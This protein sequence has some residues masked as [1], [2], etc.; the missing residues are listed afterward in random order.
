MMRVLI[1]GSSRGI[2]RET[3]LMFLHKGYEVIGIDRDNATIDHEY[4]THYIADISSVDT[5]PEIN[6]INYLINNAGTQGEDDIANNLIGTINVTEK[7]AFQPCIKSV[8]NV[9]SA[10]ALTGAEF[11]HYAASKGGVNS[12]G[13][14]VALKL[15]EYKATCNNLCPGGV[16]TDLNSPV[17]NDPDKYNAVLDETLLK[18]WASASEI[19]EWIYF[20]T[21]TN[22]FMTGQDVL[23]DGGE[24][25]KSNFIW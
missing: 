7:Y 2:G 16:L 11:A 3:A 10:S 1:T 12:Y 15:S 6:S 19:S 14:N 8:L 9:S 4:Y 13:K 21:V 25:L 23:V 22:K 18:R 24:Q 20:L 17:I 5:L